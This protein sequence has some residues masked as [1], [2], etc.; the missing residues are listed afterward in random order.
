M[1]RIAF[2]LAVLAGCNTAYVPARSPRISTTLSGGSQAY[3]RDGVEY[4]AGMFGGGLVDAVQGDPRA[5]EAA[6]TFHS[7]MVNGFLLTIAGAVCTGVVAGDILA[8]AAND[9][10]YRPS[11][12]LWAVGAGCLIAE[13][14]G[15]GMMA[16]G[17]TYAFDAINM[18]ND[19]VMISPSLPPG[20]K[21]GSGR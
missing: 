14:V 4:P 15:V 12:G 2:L 19:D 13:L 7:H 3:V 9:S 21:P 5:V 8:N 10:G 11:G 6:E 1:K 18:F 16:S 20:V 17:Q